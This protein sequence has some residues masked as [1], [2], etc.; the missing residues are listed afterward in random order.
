MPAFGYLLLLNEHVYYY[1]TVQ[2]DAGWLFNHLPSMWRVWLLFY[3][4]FFLAIGSVLFAWWCPTEVKH[5]ASAFMLVDAERAHLT[6]HNLNHQIAEKLK[7][8]YENMSKWE[9]SI[10][11]LPMLRPDLPNLGA[12]TLPELRTS[13]QWGLGLIHIWEANDIKRPALRITIFLLFWTGL[14]FLAVPAGLTFLQVTFLL[15]KNL[16]GP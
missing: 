1:L 4:S 16:L 15:V 13:D 14:V 3:G 12:G 10:F 7:A 11:K 2:Y 5:Y 6:A 8:L 9:R